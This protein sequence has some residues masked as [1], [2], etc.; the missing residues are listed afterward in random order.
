MSSLSQ[1]LVFGFSV[2]VLFVL[3]LVCLEA[4]RRIGIR[5][6][7]KGTEL[8]SAG[9]T[10]VD[11]AVFGLTGLI[12]AFTFSG[13][14]SRFDARRQLILQETNHIGTAYLRVDLLP[15]AYQ[16]TVR[17]D[18]RGY[19]DTRIAFYRHGF[20]DPEASRA[21]FAQSV[22]LQGK[23]WADAVAGCRELNSPATTSLV[24]SSLN[25]MID[26]TTTRAVATETHPPFVIYWG[27]LVL[28]LASSFL[29]GYGLADAKKPNWIH[30]V[31]YAAV[32]AAVV[33]VIF[34][35]EFPRMGLIRIDAA[36][37]ILMDLRAS[38]K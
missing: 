19:L 27:L 36:D 14:A 4:G 26:I 25:E 31:V 8:S 21:D 17:E 29:A 15:L 28:V 35:L 16:S 22:A 1:M 33:Y 18:F 5:H 37:H 3:L 20:S 13:A 34:D 12:I 11:G 30:L 10:A 23:I 7:K 38:M 6:Q 9:L 32:T 24:L 2:V